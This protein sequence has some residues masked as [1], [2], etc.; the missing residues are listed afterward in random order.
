VASDLLLTLNWCVSV[1]QTALVGVSR[2]PAGEDVGELRLK[3]DHFQ[4]VPHCLSSCAWLILCL[5]WHMCCAAAQSL[6][7]STSILYLSTGHSV[8]LSK[9]PVAR[10]ADVHGR[11]WLTLELASPLPYA[12]WISTIGMCHIAKTPALDSALV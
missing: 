10:V 11:M 8:E 5:Q 7:M 12:A 1:A 3:L 4:S 9:K 6:S 2:G